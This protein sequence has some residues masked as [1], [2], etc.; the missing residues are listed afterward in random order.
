[1]SDTLFLDLLTE[2][3]ISGSD[4]QLLAPAE[5]LLLSEE[6]RSDPTLGR[7]MFEASGTLACCDEKIGRTE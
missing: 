6:G 2:A 7:L 1:M 3:V 5:T 4:R